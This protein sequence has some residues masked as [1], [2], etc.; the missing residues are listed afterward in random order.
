MLAFVIIMTLVS[1]YLMQKQEH[2]QAEQ[3]RIDLDQI[4]RSLVLLDPKY[5]LKQILK[6]SFG[7]GIPTNLN[8]MACDCDEYESILLKHS[9]YSISSNNLIER[10]EGRKCLKCLDWP[11]RANMRVYMT[12]FDKTKQSFCYHI[13]WQSY[14]SLTTPLVDCY[15]LHGS[16]WFGIGDLLNVASWPLNNISLPKT[17]FVTGLPSRTSSSLSNDNSQANTGGNGLIIGSSS[18]RKWLSTNGILIHDIPLEIPLYVSLNHSRNKKLCLSIGDYGVKKRSYNREQNSVFETR[19]KFWPSEKSNGNNQIGNSFHRLEYSI[20]SSNNLIDIN[21]KLVQDNIELMAS[22]SNRQEEQHE[23]EPPPLSSLIDQQV[24]I[25]LNVSNIISSQS[26]ELKEDF[27]DQI[28]RPI[29]KEEKSNS[30]AE[31]NLIDILERPIFK[32]SLEY[33]SILDGQTLR[34]YMDKIARSGLSPKK[35][36]QIDSRWETYIG[37]MKLNTAR[38][39]GAELL[40]ELL[41]NKGFKIIL[42]ITPYIDCNIGMT[43]LLNLTDDGRIFVN[44]EQGFSSTSPVSSSIRSFI[45]RTSFYEIS[46]ENLNQQIHSS[47][48]NSSS[49]VPFLFHCNESADGLCS[50]IDLTQHRNRQWMIDNILR[51]NLFREEADGIYLVGGH[52]SKLWSD[53]YLEDYRL[54]AED[55][56]H[57][58]SLFTMTQFTGAFGYIQLSPRPASWQGLQSIIP[59]LFNLGLIGYSL[60]H[61]GS[62]GGD[63]KVAINRTVSSQVNELNINKA[64]NQE[65]IPLSPVFP[66]IIE[67]ELFVRWLQLSAFMPILQFNSIEAIE[68]YK[69]QEMA[70][71]LIKMRQML[72]VPDLKKNLPYSPL[73]HGKNKTSSPLINTNFLPLIR[74][75]WYLEDKRD[76]TIRDQFAIGND[77]IVAPILVQNKR[78]RDIYLPIGLWKDELR[79]QLIDGGRWMRNYR[80]DLYEIAWFSRQKE[81]SLMIMPGDH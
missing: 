24:V 7:Q 72:I 33:M 48:P 55:M 9:N 21:K 70:Q 51:S 50:L 37:S 12:P 2:L 28:M 60:I 36:I 53:R 5:G 61:P 8:P 62:V 59:S 27:N 32:T 14:D 78:Y 1:S 3:D 57:N 22:V 29:L 71:N 6:G 75:L 4:Q 34:L 47:H 56:L 26:Q 17:P 80:V 46:Y 16:H 69:L 74:P 76:F 15:D 43:N 40:F 81:E 79:Q 54:L 41:H 23:E 39:P 65:P 52:P 19:A 45:R 10:Q 66:K 58:H 42:A 20:C 38:F 13:K 44:S 35:I 31:F 11:Y 77:I 18:S 63:F 25:N 68:K 67:E 49:K 73:V 30:R 64:N